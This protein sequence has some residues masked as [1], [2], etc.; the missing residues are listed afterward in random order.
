MDILKMLKYS[1]I[2][3]FCD[4]DHLPLRRR[5][6]R[7]CSGSQTVVPLVEQRQESLQSELTYLSSVLLMRPSKWH[8]GFVV[9]AENKKNASSEF[10]RC[11]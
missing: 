7:H 4:N 6:L 5:P 9:S 10:H 1:K 8:S 3:Y 11:I 2:Q